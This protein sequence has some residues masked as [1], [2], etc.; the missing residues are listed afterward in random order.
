[1]KTNPKQFP[2]NFF[3]GGA[4]A[5]N[6]LEGAFLED[7]KGWSVADINLF[8]DDIDLKKK[9]NKEVDTEFIKFAMEDKVG[10]YPKRQGIDFYRTY[11]DDLKMLA[12][13][14][15]NSFRT[16][17]DWSRIFP[18]GDDEAPNEAGLKY[19][20]DLFDT[21]N[22]LGME[23]LITLS[24]YEI[25]LNLTLKYN[26][27]YSR[28]TIEF[29]EK[30]AKVVMER[31]KD[32]VR[33]WILV[34]Q[35]NMI[36]HESFNHLGIPSD[37]VENLTQ[38]KYQGLHNELVACGRVIR[39]AKQINS[40]F[41]I[42]MM[43]YYGHAAPATNKPE[44]VLA[45][46]RQNQLEYF[47][48][49][50]LV[51]GKY[52]NYMYRFL[53]ESNINIEFGENDEEDLK[54][55]VDY[56]TFSY[57]YTQ[58]VSAESFADGHKT[59]FNP[60]LPANDWGWSIDPVGLRSALNLFYDRYQLPIM[61]TENGMGFLEDL[62]SDNTIEDDYRIEFLRAHIEQMKEAIHDGVELIG[63]YPWGPIDLVSCSSSEMSK[64][65]GFIYV[66]IDD[67]GQGSKK[68]F[69]K[70]SFNWYK[71]VIESNGEVLG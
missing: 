28:Q 18:N 49:D 3:W 43:S 48:P 44:D 61:I 21:L 29:F 20:D 1:M 65:Y 68:R 47:V 19:Y 64:R 14:G 45:S 31:Y 27:W 55:T 23:P 2:K 59:L 25:P 54:N 6:Q 36:T 71:E 67:Y 46:V 60:N 15:M 26:G 11:K 30:Y 56:V 69:K 22:E 51:R 62:N 17:I 40:G 70:K 33:Y 4:V 37:S 5:A 34:N 38:A 66:D 7:G 9:G 63:F 35:M 10:R 39:N 13:M 53:E 32:K 24:H 12:D 52:P 57:Y 50:V 42:G 16:S 8:R 41:Q 58:I